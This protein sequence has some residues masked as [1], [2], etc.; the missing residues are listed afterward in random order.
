MTTEIKQMNVADFANKAFNLERSSKILSIEKNLID[1]GFTHLNEWDTVYPIQ[2]WA[3]NH[4]RFSELGWQQQLDLYNLTM[5]EY[6]SGK[7]ICKKAQKE[8]WQKFP[9][10]MKSTGWCYNWGWMKLFNEEL[11]WDL[12]IPDVDDNTSIDNA[13]LGAISMGCKVGLQELVDQLP[14]ELYIKTKTL[15]ILEEYVQF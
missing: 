10:L 8:L 4:G 14:I 13:I 2:K 5:A 7:S 3:V 6:L 12:N 15:R 11:G 9:N 1:K